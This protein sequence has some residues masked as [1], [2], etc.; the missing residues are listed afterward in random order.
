MTIGGM[1]PHDNWRDEA[2]QNWMGEAIQTGGIFMLTFSI[3]LTH[4]DIK[5]LPLSLLSHGRLSCN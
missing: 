5:L 1:K 4:R 2:T 3:Q